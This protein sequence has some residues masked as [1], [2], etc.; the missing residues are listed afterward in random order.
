MSK[1]GQN[2]IC[3][4]TASRENGLLSGLL[5]AFTFPSL[6]FS[7]LV[8]GLNWD[9]NEGKVGWDGVKVDQRKC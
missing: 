8:P 1:L 9:L 3:A 7:L 5:K 2:K 4:K 6:P